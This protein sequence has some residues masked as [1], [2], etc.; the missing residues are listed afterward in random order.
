MTEEEL[1]LKRLEYSRR[2]REEGPEVDS[3]SPL[4][5]FLYYLMRDHLPVGVVAEIL[6]ESQNTETTKFSNGYLA[7]YAQHLARDLVNA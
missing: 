1:D 4:V 7:Q 5:K 3:N 6:V 2:L